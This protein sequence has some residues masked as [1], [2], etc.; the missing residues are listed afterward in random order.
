[1]KK[2]ISLCLLAV[3]LLTVPAMADLIW[4]PDDDFYSSHRDQ[5]DYLG[6]SYYVNGPQGGTALWRKEPGGGHVRVLENGT[7]LYISF[8]YTDQAGTVWGV[9]EYGGG[10]GWVDMED[11]LLIYDNQSFTEEHEA[12]FSPYDD[13]FR[14]LCTSEDRRVIIWTY[15]GSGEINCDFDAL[16]QDY[17]ALQPDVTWT[18]G[19]GRVWGRIGYYMAAR[20]WVCLS[21][22]GNDALPVTE[23]TYD[24]YPVGDLSRIGQAP[25]AFRPAGLFLVCLGVAAVCGITAV[26]LFRMRKKNH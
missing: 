11:L 26:L 25:A 20:G 24:L 13:S 19:E 2:W 1:M 9:T 16:S 22:P 6:R 15:P 18:D 8:T 4:E 3:C 7:R 10:T 23:R 14:E 17:S 5:C 12:E 21:D